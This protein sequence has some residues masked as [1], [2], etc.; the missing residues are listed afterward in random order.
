M[1]ENSYIPVSKVARASKF[2]G[3]GLKVGANYLKYSIQKMGNS[4][5]DKEQLHEDNAKDIYESLSVLKGSALKVTQMLSMD[6]GM[7]PRAYRDAFAMAQYSAPPLSG[8]LVV[9]TFQSELGKSPGLIFDQ[10]DLK[11]SFAASIG[12]VHRAEK[13]GKVFAVKV[14]YPGV[15]NSIHADLKMIKPIA[16]AMFSLN[17]KDVDRYMSEVQDK[18][19]EETNYIQEMNY[20]QEITEACKGLEGILFPQYYPEYS[21]S[22]IL[23]MDW[24]EGMHLKEFLA[25]KPSQEIRNLIGQRLWD[26]Y[27]FQIHTLKMVHADPHPG[28]FLM[29]ADGKLGILDFGC[30][31]TIPASF[32]DP[33]FALL[34]TSILKEKSK[35]MQIFEDLEFI[36]PLDSPKEK[37][38]FFELFTSMIDLLARPFQTSTFDFS[39]VSYVDEIYQMADEL[40]NN[41]QLRYSKHARGSQHGLYINRTY[42]GLYTLLHELG[43]EIVIR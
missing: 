5:L 2:V 7:L 35:T 14:Q 11:A 28:N 21:S 40:K 25:T 17:A 30:V 13:D 12:Q 24:L 20:A 42:F 29:H 22:K 19:L 36:N 18:L 9:K 10:F 16:L 3:T 27:D 4:A 41:D 6:R 43:S 23:C 26:F 1:K 39:D 34:D 8:P 15:A 31:K 37:E 38:D 33:Y 32:Y